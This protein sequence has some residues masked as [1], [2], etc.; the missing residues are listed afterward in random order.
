MDSSVSIYEINNKNI[1]LLCSP[2]SH[3]HVIIYWATNQSEDFFFCIF[4]VFDRKSILVLLLSV[5][6]DIGPE[7]IMEP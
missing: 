2:S 7:A 1:S 6:C 4:A 3:I 5:L